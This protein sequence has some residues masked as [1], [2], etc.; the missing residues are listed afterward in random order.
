M[1]WAIALILFG[2]WVLGIASGASLGWWIHLMLL[3]ALVSAAM[4]TVGQA[5]RI[6]RGNRPRNTGTR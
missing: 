1:A 4:G 3:G 2:N 6:R 5:A